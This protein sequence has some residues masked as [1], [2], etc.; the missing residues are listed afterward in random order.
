MRR[1]QSRHPFELVLLGVHA[2]KFPA[3]RDLAHLRAAVRQ[4]GIEHPVVQDPDHVV[5]QAWAAR[6]WPTVALVDPEGRVIGMASGEIDADKLGDTLGRLIPV[7]EARGTLARATPTA[8]PP[9]PRSRTLAH[10]SKLLVTS[11]STLFVADSGHHRILQ[12]EVDDAHRS[13][14]IEREIGSGT[15]GF[16][17]GALDVARFHDPHGMAASGS[18]LYVADTGN[19]AI[20]AV[21]LAQGIV[22][23]IAGTG[24]IGHAPVQDGGDP[25]RIPL[26]SP[27]SLWLD[28]PR[29]FVALAGSHQ[30]VVIEDE[31]DLRPFA[32]NGAERLHDGP[33]LQ[34][35]FNQPSDLVGGGGAL[36]IA[37]PEASAI[38]R[39]SLI[40]R[41]VVET[42]VG[43]GLFDWGD[44]D[45]F[46]P[47][48]RLQHPMGLALDGLLYVADTYNH[49]IKHM[50]VA[51]QQV[52]ALAG[53]GE[54]GHQD[55]GFTRARF[56]R[57][58]GLVVRGRHLFVAD[59]GNHVIRVCDLGSREVWTLT[60][61][62]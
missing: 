60:I 23:T 47:R 53:S 30:V 51:S 58:E 55:G 33:A 35:G 41:P 49:R 43:A 21:D 19:H 28:R 50:D 59:T 24:S 34:A 40:G 42:L 20:R 32:G 25:L 54:P 7:Y 37:D 36:Y 5:W 13:A 9:A 1:V 57:P 52:A 61:A 18:T 46:G 22:R 8:P 56:R 39:V 17:D 10:P 44:V 31:L 11:G 26:R 4:L 6:A 15:P 62:D 14:R 12:L 45:G 48:V 2:P 38:R 3:E 29:L 27:W 16:A